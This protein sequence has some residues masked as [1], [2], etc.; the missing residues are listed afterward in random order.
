MAK[1][2]DAVVDGEI[3]YIANTGS[4]KLYSYN[5]ITDRWSQLPD[6]A[7]ECCSITSVNG[8]LTTVGGRDYPTYSNEL[9]CLSREG[10]GV[11]WTRK[12][13][14]MPTKRQWTTSLCIGSTLIVAGGQGE[15]GT[16]ST[17]ELMVT[18]TMQ[19]F[20]VA[21]LPQP[22]YRAS[23]SLCGDQLYMV[24]GMVKTWA[25]TKSVY[26]CSVS[27]LRQSCTPLKGRV[28]QKS[29]ND[30]PQVWRQIADLP[31][32]DSTCES[33]LGRLLAVCG[34]DKDPTIP[35]TAVY[36]YNPNTN[37]WEVIS[38]MTTGRFM[39]FT[40]VLPDNQLMVVGGE[41]NHHNW[42]DAVEIASV[43]N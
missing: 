19:W 16:L 7:H 23:A 2:C 12:F 4:V 34:Y 29:L 25:A 33:F 28:K 40:A 6:C 9:F 13:P 20:T 21:D 24:G 8:W 5:A 42:T 14:R 35:T 43:C 15:S 22:V 41:S 3:V 1:Y 11:R 30:S 38:H 37:S 32:V 18:E 36:M 10:S 31:V 17:V 27:C 39:C 26:S